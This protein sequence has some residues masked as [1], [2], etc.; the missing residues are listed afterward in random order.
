LITEKTMPNILVDKA[1][2]VKEIFYPIAVSIASI[3]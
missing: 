2:I 1:D 3:F